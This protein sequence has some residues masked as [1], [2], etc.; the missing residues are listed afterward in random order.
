M[1]F[2]CKYVSQSLN[3]L[4]HRIPTYSARFTNEVQVS[5]TCNGEAMI[6]VPRKEWERSETSLVSYLVSLGFVFRCFWPHVPSDPM[7]LC[8][9]SQ[10]MKREKLLDMLDGGQLNSKL[11]LTDIQMH[12]ISYDYFCD[13]DNI[14]ILSYS[15][16]IQFQYNRSIHVIPCHL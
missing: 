9:V 6:Q 15:D 8:T 3:I 1:I 10:V 11:T 7:S 13:N 12:M 2:F 5:P 14:Y 16:T 4:K